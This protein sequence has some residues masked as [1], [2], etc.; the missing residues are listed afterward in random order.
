MEKMI[1]D[2]QE[3]PDGVYDSEDKDKLLEESFCKRLNLVL[4]QQWLP[5]YVP[6]ITAHFEYR[7]KDGKVVSMMLEFKMNHQCYKD[8]EQLDI[9]CSSYLMLDFE[10]D[11]KEGRVYFEADNLYD[12]GRFI[13]SM[14][15]YSFN[16]EGGLFA[17][18]DKEPYVKEAL[19]KWKRKEKADFEERM[20]DSFEWKEEDDD[21]GD[22]YID[23]YKVRYSKDRK[24]LICA[25]VGFN[26]QEYRVPDGVEEICGYSFWESKH[27]VELSLPRSIKRIGSNV[28]F[29][30]GGRFV[31]R[32][33]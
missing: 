16:I 26:R 18:V 1:I 17:I 8:L 15:F 24:I 2:L 22:D 9:E 20:K 30:T 23:E 25:M 32:D 12:M 6:K 3:L 4:R 29:D 13:E 33:E 31:F 11:E 5:P 10:I 27:Y 21:L 7:V 14:S 28:F 19:I